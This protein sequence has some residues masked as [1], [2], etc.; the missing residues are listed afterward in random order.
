MSDPIAAETYSVITEHNSLEN[1]ATSFNDFDGC[2]VGIITSD[3]DST[4]AFVSRDHDGLSQNGGRVAPLAKLRK[5]SVA[6]VSPSGGEKVIQLKSDRRP[7][8]ELTVDVGREKGTT[9]SVLGQIN[10]LPVALHKSG[11][12]RPGHAR[13]IVE[14]EKISSTAL[15]RRPCGQCGRFVGGAEWSKDKRYRGTLTLHR[16]A[17]SAQ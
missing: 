12:L 9:N 11:P 2:H 8:Y 13:V 15:K 10:P 4:N 1:S 14:R 7:T 6:D 5:N 3:Q 17:P 16:P